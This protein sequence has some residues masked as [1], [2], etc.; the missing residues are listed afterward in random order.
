MHTKKSAR[1]KHPQDA[2]SSPDAHRDPEKIAAN[3]R[4]DAPTCY[5]TPH[6]LRVSRF[7]LTGPEYGEVA[8]VF[9]PEDE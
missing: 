4:R 1:T 9:R 8:N 3:S 6:N 7:L 2:L 5:E